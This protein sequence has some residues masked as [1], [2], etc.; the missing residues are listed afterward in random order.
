MGKVIPDAAMDAE[1]AYIAAADRLFI[2]TQE[3]STYAEASVTYNM[4]S[5]TLTPGAGNGDFA[6]ANGDAS[7]RKLTVAEQAG[8]NVDSGDDATHV[9]LALSSDE[10]LRLIT[11]CTTKTMAE[12][13]TVTVPS[14]KHEIADPT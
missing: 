2:C 6:I 4:A 7:G 9:V 13:D 10:S 11:T 3:P 1:L 8:L 12:N 5:A 14:F